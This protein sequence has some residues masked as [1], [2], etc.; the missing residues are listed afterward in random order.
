MKLNQRAMKQLEESI[1][2][3]QALEKEET[4]LAS[5]LAGTRASRKAAIDIEEDQIKELDY[6]LARKQAL[7]ELET[8]K[9][10]TLQQTIAQKHELIESE[11]ARIKELELL[12]AEKRMHITTE[13]NTMKELTQAKA[14]KDAM[15][16]SEQNVVSELQKTQ[17]EKERIIEVQKETETLIQSDIKKEE[18]LRAFKHAAIESVKEARATLEAE[19]KTQRFTTVALENQIARK[20]SLITKEAYV[21]KCLQHMSLHKREF[22]P[23]GAISYFVNAY[24]GMQHTADSG[25][26]FL[27]KE[28]HLASDFVKTHIREQS[29]AVRKKVSKRRDE[30]LAL[31]PAVSVPGL[32]ICKTVVSKGPRSLMARLMSFGVNVDLFPKGYSGSTSPGKKK[33][34]TP[35]SKLPK[36]N[37][38]ESE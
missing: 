26:K 10:K 33:T 21:A 9:E 4:S 38:N 6:T 14:E 22:M 31:V 36:W 12:I 20:R 5:R 3:K 27:L 24:F 16:V 18:A 11:V 34:P 29:A 32:G 7:I 30:V 2:K 8:M 28:T 17:E 37:K 13:R 1:A 15:L 23:P 35:E 19:L 25:M